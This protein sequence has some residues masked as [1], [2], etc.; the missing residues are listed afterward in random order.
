MSDVR[1]ILAERL[2]R[3]RERIE[4]ACSRAGREASSVTLVAVTKTVDPEVA[5]LLAE[6]GV[7][8]LGES[9]PQELWRKAEALKH[10]PIRWHLIGHLQRNK[11]ERSLPLAHLI[12]SVDSF[13]L[14]NEVAAEGTKQGLRPRVLLQVNASREGQKHGFEFDELLAAVAELREAPVDVLGLMGMAALSDNPEEARPAFAELRRFRD[15]LRTATGLPLEQLSMGMSGDF[16][17][18]IEE[19][20]TL[21]RIGTTLFEGLDAER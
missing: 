19:A 12:H 20:S 21:V 14:L 5:G 10:L 17:V 13:R 8:D 15:L 11:V 3:V 6:L 2:A 9:R 1:A 16:E 4:A 18:A 7:L